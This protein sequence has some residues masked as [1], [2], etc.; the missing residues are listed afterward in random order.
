MISRRKEIF[1][2]IYFIQIKMVNMKMNK[3]RIIV[4]KKFNQNKNLK[5]Q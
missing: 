5:K 4:V 2:Q 3:K 1:L